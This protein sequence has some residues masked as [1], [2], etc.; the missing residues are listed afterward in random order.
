MLRNINNPFE[1]RPIEVLDA[2]NREPIMRFRTISKCREYLKLSKWHIQ[3][4]NQILHCKK[5][6]KN[7]ILIEY[8]EK[9]QSKTGIVL[10]KKNVIN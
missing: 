9:W 7:V 8:K 4:L 1:S 2:L 10:V 3:R 5:L 6:N